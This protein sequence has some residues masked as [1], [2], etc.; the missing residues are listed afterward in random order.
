MAWLAMALSLLVALVGAVGLVSPERLLETLR[1]FDSPLGLYGA[2]AL[3]IALGG[4]LLLSAPASRVPRTLQA[5]GF[6]ILVAGFITPFF[7]V[8]RLRAI[9]DWWS[10]QGSDLLRAWSGFALGLGSFMAYAVL[11]RPQ[12]D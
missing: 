9:L 4:A 5:L 11:P 8:D 7:G 2:A 1:H 10:G 12:A 3:R 6:V